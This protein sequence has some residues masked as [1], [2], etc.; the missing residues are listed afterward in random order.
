MPE[1]TFWRVSW[2]NSPCRTARDGSDKV[3][4]LHTALTIVGESHDGEDHAKASYHEEGRDREPLPESPTMETTKSESPTRENAMQARLSGEC[5][6]T[7]GP[8]GEFCNGEDWSGKFAHC[9]R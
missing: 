3:E 9:M 8:T 1:R 4:E 6:D 2:F 5:H 7:E